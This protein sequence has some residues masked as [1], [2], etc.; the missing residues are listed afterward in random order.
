MTLAAQRAEGTI[1][2][3]ADLLRRRA[4][5]EPADI[6]LN[7][8]LKPFA[9]VWPQLV[10]EGM[11]V[12]HCNERAVSTRVMVTASGESAFSLHEPAHHGY[13]ATL[14]QISQRFWWPRVR[15][16]GLHS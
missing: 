6:E 12:K 5:L 10:L 3:V 7:P 15:A 13:E 14:R 9:D 4:R 16:D 11:L 2:F 1:S 8:Q